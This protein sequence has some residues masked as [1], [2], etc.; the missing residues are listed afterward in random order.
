M[1][2]PKINA[3]IIS[4]DN[5]LTL[6]LCIEKFNQTFSKLGITVEKTDVKIECMKEAE[7][8]GKEEERSPITE[9]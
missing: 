7:E 3:G 8:N 4:I 9:Q 5:I 2:G 6:E 1:G